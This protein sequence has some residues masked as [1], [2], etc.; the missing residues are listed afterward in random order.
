MSTA[1]DDGRQGDLLTVDE[2][3]AQ[4]SISRSLLR[5]ELLKHSLPVVRIGRRLFIPSQTCDDL[6]RLGMRPFQPHV[7]G[8]GR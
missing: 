6:I 5:G 7:R 4:L 3:C 8:R 1:D 2:A